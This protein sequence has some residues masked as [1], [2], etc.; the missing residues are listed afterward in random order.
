MDTLNAVP[1]EMQFPPN[2]VAGPL[3][4]QLHT[5]LQTVNKTFCTHQE[6]VAY[7]TDID[8]DFVFDV[9]SGRYLV[10]MSGSHIDLLAALFRYYGGIEPDK[11]LA[12]DEYVR[13]GMGLFKSRAGHR[14]YRGESFVVPAELFSI[15]RDIEVFA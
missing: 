15:Q 1:A 7:Y 10:G 8:T 2:P 13:S 11:Y 6:F 5:A 3:S 4:E 14:I 12:A 9:R